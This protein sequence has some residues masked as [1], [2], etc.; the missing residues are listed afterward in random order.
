MDCLP[1]LMAITGLSKVAGCQRKS[2]PTWLVSSGYSAWHFFID[3]VF[4]IKY[5]EL[6][7]YF[8]NSAVYFKTF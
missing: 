1:K 6:A 8:D 5:P 3:D 7:A 4:K 2:P